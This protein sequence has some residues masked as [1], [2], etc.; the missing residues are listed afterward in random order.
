LGLLTHF[1]HLSTT[2]LIIKYFRIGIF[3]VEYNMSERESTL[4]K[5]FSKEENLNGESSL[6]NSTSKVDLNNL[7]KRVKDEEKRS[8]RQNIVISA[9]ALSAVAV[10]GIILTL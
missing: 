10:F 5:E 7:I 1:E 9:A 2:F 3:V 8:K 4:Q 6:G